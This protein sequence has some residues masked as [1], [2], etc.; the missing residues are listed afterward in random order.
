MLVRDWASL[1]V[2][3]I[4]RSST[5]YF[6]SGYLTK[7]LDFT[8]IYFLFYNFTPHYWWAEE[9]WGWQV[10]P[11]E[12]MKRVLW[13]N[14]SYD[15]LKLQI[16][17]RLGLLPCFKIVLCVQDRDMAATT[18]HSVTHSSFHS[19]SYTWCRA[20]RLPRADIKLL[21]SWLILVNFHYNITIC[22]LFSGLS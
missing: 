1:C 20:Q 18:V 12:K 14:Q 22:A 8:Q 17:P 6:C 13:I 9:A 11:A 5:T 2:A 3:D 16:S 7:M 4:D 21:V 19:S 10:V 15:W